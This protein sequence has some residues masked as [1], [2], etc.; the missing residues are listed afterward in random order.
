VERKVHKLT[1][2]EL[3]DSPIGK[4]RQALLVAGRLDTTR[5]ILELVEDGKLAGVVLEVVSDGPMKGDLLHLTTGPSG[6]PVPQSNQP[7]AT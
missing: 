6:V 3:P 2:N 1:V 5:K 4:D 7:W